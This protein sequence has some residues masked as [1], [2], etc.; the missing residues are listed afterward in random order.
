[1][2]LAVPSEPEA[3]AARLVGA[4]LGWASPNLLWMLS[5]HGWLDGIGFGLWG[6]LGWRRRAQTA[7]GA[8]AS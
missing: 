3:L 8:A 4:R 6:A 5:R 7:A 2:P 1:M